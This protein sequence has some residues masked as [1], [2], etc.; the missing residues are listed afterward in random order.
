MCVRVWCIPRAIVHMQRLED[1][2]PELISPFFF[3]WVSGMEL[4]SIG[5]LHQVSLSPV[6]LP[7]SGPQVLPIL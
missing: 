7:G 3:I 2:F 1:N 6:I 4:R 5:L